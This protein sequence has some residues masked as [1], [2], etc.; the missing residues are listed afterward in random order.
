VKGVR[1]CYKIE[2]L[3]HT[4]RFLIP[5]PFLFLDYRAYPRKL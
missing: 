5:N 1:I 4:S 3:F 2:A